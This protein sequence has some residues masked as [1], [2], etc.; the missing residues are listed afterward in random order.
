LGTTLHHWPRVYV[1]GLE[2]LLRL[3]IA[4]R[5]PVLAS[6]AE[7]PPLYCVMAHGVAYVHVPDG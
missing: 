2:G 4:E 1:D 5:R 7:E 6:A 3:A